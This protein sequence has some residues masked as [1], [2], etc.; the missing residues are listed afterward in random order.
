MKDSEWSKRHLEESKRVN[1][2][3][4]LTNMW[5]LAASGFDMFPQVTSMEIK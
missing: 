2:D 4:I 3:N 1:E 5:D